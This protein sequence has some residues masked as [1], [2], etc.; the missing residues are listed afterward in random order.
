ML[1]L[2]SLAAGG[3]HGTVFFS[4]RVADAARFESVANGQPPNGCRFCGTSEDDDDD[5]YYE[6]ALRIEREEE[7]GDV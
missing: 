3:G 2:D 6:E 1:Q 5:Y 4:T 7:E